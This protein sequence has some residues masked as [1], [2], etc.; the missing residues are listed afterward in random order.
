MSPPLAQL[1]PGSQGGWARLWSA[2]DYEPDPVTAATYGGGALESYGGWLYWG[3]MHVPGLAGVAHA[4]VYGPTASDSEATDRATGTWRAFSVFR[5][6]GWGTPK[7]KVELLYGG[8][9]LQTVPKGG[10]FQAYLCPSGMSSCDPS[11]RTWRTV[12]NKMGLKPRY[13]RS[14]IG[15]AYNNYCWTMESWKGRLYVGTMDHSYLLYGSGAEIP[16]YLPLLAGVPEFGADLYRF[17]DARSRARPL[18]RDGMGNPMNYGIRTMISDTAAVY[19]GSANP[20]NLSPDGGWELI[21][22]S[23]RPRR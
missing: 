13:G 11:L 16:W 1:D 9:P 21:R 19:L 22:L 6:R 2:A 8:S 14:G 17:D 15:N 5:G 12:Q 10:A 3:T 4:R 23:K 18:S 20:M 7:Q